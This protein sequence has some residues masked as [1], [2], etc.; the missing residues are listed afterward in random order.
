MKTHLALIL[1]TVIW[2][3]TKPAFGQSTYLFSNF[4]GSGS[5]DAPVFDAVGSRL[6]GTNYVALLYG[7]PSPSSLAP[8]FYHQINLIMPAPF[9][10][11]ALGLGGYF[12]GGTVL[13][14]P[15]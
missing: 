4:L 2:Q 7:G 11:T 10:Y 5:L 6:S 1:A 9:T 13:V 12:S 3:Q 15:S 8:A 14:N